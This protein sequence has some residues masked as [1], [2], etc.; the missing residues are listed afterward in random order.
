MKAMGLFAIV[1]VVLIGGISGCQKQ[2][3]VSSEELRRNSFAHA[4]PANCRIPALRERQIAQAPTTPA[5]AARKPATPA[6]AARTETTDTPPKPLVEEYDPQTQ[7]AED[8][9]AMAG[10]GGHVNMVRLPDD[11]QNEK[12]FK[13]EELPESVWR[14]G[15]KEEAE[16]D[17]DLLDF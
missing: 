14:N 3:Q 6:P 4:V 10:P 8:L 17:P 7:P 13:T 5:P 1:A 2:R 16:I 15:I 12:V 9:S 11:Y